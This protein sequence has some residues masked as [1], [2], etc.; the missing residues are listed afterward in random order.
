[1][2]RVISQLLLD[3]DGYLHFG[4]HVSHSEFHGAFHILRD[5]L[6]HFIRL[7]PKHDFPQLVNLVVGLK[8]IDQ[9]VV[10]VKL[11]AVEAK[12]TVLCNGP[13]VLHVLDY[14]NQLLISQEIE[15]IVGGPFGL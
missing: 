5:R 1:L 6:E 15:T 12:P 14:R 4:Y 13:R 7:A 3:I 9:F 8:P 2:Q 11:I 10:H